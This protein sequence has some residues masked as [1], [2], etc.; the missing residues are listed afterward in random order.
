MEAGK[1][2]RPR[3][4]EKSARQVEGDAAATREERDASRLSDMAISPLGPDARALPAQ[5]RPD[6][7]AARLVFPERFGGQNRP[8]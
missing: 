1:P 2:L 4:V 6:E 7:R 3:R 5:K 8:L